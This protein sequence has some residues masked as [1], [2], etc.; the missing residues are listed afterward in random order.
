V[1]AS[2]IGAIELAKK[3]ADKEGISLDLIIVDGGNA[4]QLIQNHYNNDLPIKQEANLVLKGLL[5]WQQS[6]IRK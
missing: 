3:Y 4:T 5:A 6:M 1:L 2:Q